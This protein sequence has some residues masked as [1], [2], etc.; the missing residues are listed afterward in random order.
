[1]YNDNI[2]E[3]YLSKLNTSSEYMLR[4]LFTKLEKR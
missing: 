3:E 2:K 4:N 1:M